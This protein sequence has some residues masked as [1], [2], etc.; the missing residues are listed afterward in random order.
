[1]SPGQGPGLYGK[2]SKLLALLPKKHAGNRQN[3]APSFGELVIWGTEL[4]KV[5]LHGYRVLPCRADERITA[6]GFYA[7]KATAEQLPARCSL[8]PNEYGGENH[9]TLGTVMRAWWD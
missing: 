8:E 6:E 9:P 1:M 7:P 3:D 4:G 2:R 5:W